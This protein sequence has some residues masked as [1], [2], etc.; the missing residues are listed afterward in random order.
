MV[1]DAGRTVRPFCPPPRS[2][3]SMARLPLC[4]VVNTLLPAPQ[5]LLPVSQQP[6][7]QP[8][9]RPAHSAGASDFQGCWGMTLP[10]DRTAL[11][12]SALP[13]DL[14]WQ[15]PKPEIGSEGH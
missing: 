6:H 11:P 4:L 8:L 10:L 7:T 13:Q 5:G 12:P 2:S 9:A 3:H 15:L 14:A 1:F